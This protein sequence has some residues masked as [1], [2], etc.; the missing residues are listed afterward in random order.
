[1]P[2]SF[3]FWAIKHASR[4]QNIFPIKFNENYT[5]PH[6]LVYK[7]R[8]DYRQLFWLFSTTYFS[9]KKDNTKART[10]LQSHTLTGIAVGWS[11]VANGLLVYNPITKELYTTS[12]YK[13]DEHHATKSYF[14]LPYDGRMFTGLYSIDSKQN[15]PEPYPIGTAVSIASNTGPSKGYIFA[16]PSN[17]SPNIDEDPLYTIKLLDGNTTSVPASAME[18]FIDKTS[19]SIQITL[20]SWLRHDAKVRYT[21]GKITHQ[22]RLHLGSKNTWKFVVHNKLGSIIRQEPLDNLPF[23]FESLIKEQRL[24][25]GWLNHPHCSAFNV[26]A[27]SLTNECPPTLKKALHQSN[28]DQPTWLKSYQQEF[29]DLKNMDVYDEISDDEYNKI[30]HKCGKPIPTMCVLTIKYKNGYPDRAKCRIVVLGNQQQHN[31]SKGEKYAP[32]ITQNQFR[33]LL[34]LAI[35]NKQ[36][37]KQ[38]D[39]KNTFCN[40]TLPQDELVVIKPPKGCPLSRPNTLWKLKKTLYGL[41]HSPLHWFN[42]ISTFFKSIGLSNLPNSP[43]MFSSTIVPGEPP[44]YVGLYVDDFAFFSVSDKVE[45]KFKTLLNSTYTVSYEDQLEWFL[46]MKFEWKKSA[47]NLKCLVHQEAFILDIVDRY[48]LSDCNTL[49]R[50]TPFR[51]GFPVDTIAPSEL[52]EAQQ[53]SLTKKFQQVIGDLN[54]LSISTRLDITAIV[55]LLSAHSH[56]PAPAHFDAALHVVKYLASTPSI[57]LYY[58][59]DNNEDFH[60]FVHFPPNK[61]YSF[62]AYCNANWGPMD[63]SVPKPGVIPPEQSLDSLRSLSGWFIMNTGA[64]I[65]WGCARHKDTAQSS[66]QAEVHSIN[67]TT[68]LLLEYKLLSQDIGLPL[69]ATIPIK[70]DNQGAI[71]WSKGTTTKKMRWVDLQENLVRENILNQNVQVSHI[72]SKTN[73]SN[74]LTKEFCDVTQ[75]LYLRDLFMQSCAEFSSGQPP[76][77]CTWRST[78]KQALTS[79]P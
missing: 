19:T 76:V 65:A 12:I 64:P 68:K 78:Y 23:T 42:N 4:I 56:N 46:G 41:V 39:V 58:T 21:V 55:S 31:F 71:Q 15:V 16:I 28:V 18:H 43:C 69:T 6:E 11:D 13:M 50:A 53:D 54:W 73:L 79:L 36:I 48:N 52:P 49:T 74:I 72:P 5:T 3:W 33:F 67:E 75:F 32:V 77:G 9:H 14:N 61:S 45:E 26:P 47:Q 57:G 51:S 63:A 10:N 25:P 20:P 7:K 38:G 70:N 60:A 62:Q 34:S 24:Q 59:S 17:T 35:K 2:K 30:K 40:G 22:G 29:F 66:C 37:L 8:P 44:L 27:K 1:M